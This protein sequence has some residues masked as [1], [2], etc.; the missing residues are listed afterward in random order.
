LVGDPNVTD[1]D[2]NDPRDAVTAKAGEI[3]RLLVFGAVRGGFDCNRLLTGEGAIVRTKLRDDVPGEILSVAGPS[4]LN[5]KGVEVFEGSTI[6]RT[7]DIRALGLKPLPL[8]SEGMWDPREEF[9]EVLAEVESGEV[10]PDAMPEWA[11]SILAAGPRPQYEM[12]QVLPGL[13]PSG[14]SEDP[15]VAASW[16]NSTG[17]RGH[18]RTIL[19]SLL[20]RDL[21]CLDAHAHLGTYEFDRAPAQALRHYEVGAGIGGLSCGPDFRGVLPWSLIDNRPY[22]RCLHGMGLIF[23]RLGRHAEAA[24]ALRRVLWLNPGDHQGVRFVLPHVAAGEP[25][26]DILS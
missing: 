2:S 22:L 12:E 20:A 4:K 24:E 23:W 5:S 11:A 19:T 13:D 18:A 16:F 17:R 6:V 21:R 26:R 14:K 15:I 10:A 25:W 1:R 9:S 8:R 3:V 7:I